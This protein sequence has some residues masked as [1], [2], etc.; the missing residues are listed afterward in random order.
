MYRL[1]GGEWKLKIPCDVSPG[2]L[3]LM[4]ETERGTGIAYLT[5]PFDK[6]GLWEWSRGSMPVKNST[7]RLDDV[8][9][10]DVGSDDEA[11]AAYRSG[12]VKIRQHGVWS[13][14][15]LLNPDVRDITFVK[16]RAGSD[17]WIGTEHG[18]LLYR[19]S[20]SRW[21]FIKH[22][23]PDLRNYANEL[24]KTR[25][26]KL[27]VATSDGVETHRPDGRV[28]YVTRINSRPL[29]VVTGLAE[30]DAGGGWVF[31]GVSFRRA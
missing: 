3:N 11:I 13:L 23:S 10:L 9:S 8:R 17:L 16:F 1:D 5:Y 19:R 26:G 28:D 14:L 22:D 7:E 2:L 6:R 15:E 21:R 20:S 12:D 29:Y 30:D 27:W 18:L 31:N 4:A 25:D 24:L